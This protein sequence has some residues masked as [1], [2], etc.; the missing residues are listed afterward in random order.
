MVRRSCK[1]GSV[2]Q[3]EHNQLPFRGAGQD[4]TAPLPEDMKKELKK[5]GFDVDKYDTIC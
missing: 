2:A 4:L 1:T 3:S 5:S